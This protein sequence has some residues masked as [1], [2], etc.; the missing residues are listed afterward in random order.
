[1]LA[2]TVPSSIGRRRYSR[3]RRL[4]PSEQ[5]SQKEHW[6]EFAREDPM[7]YIACAP[8]GTTPEEFFAAGKDLSEWV[9]EWLGTENTGGTML[10]IGCGLGRMLH[11]FA[12]SFEHVD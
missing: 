9:L 7:F 5:Q 2:A 8:K 4:T 12:P 6:R 1:M 10:E 3:R 11:H